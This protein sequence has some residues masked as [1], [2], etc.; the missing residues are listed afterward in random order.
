M[1]YWLDD[2][3][4]AKYLTHNEGEKRTKFTNTWI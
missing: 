4:I 1:K 3:D 2:N